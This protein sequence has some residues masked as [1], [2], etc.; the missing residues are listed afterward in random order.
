MSLLITI[1]PADPV[2]VCPIGTEPFSDGVAPAWTDGTC[3]ASLVGS[4]CVVGTEAWDDDT[5]FDDN[6]CWQE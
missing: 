1:V 4:G 3:W 6:Q 5:G 2:G